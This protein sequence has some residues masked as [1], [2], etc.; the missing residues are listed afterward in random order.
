MDV[1]VAELLARALP[2]SVSTAIEALAP[3][4]KLFGGGLGE[5]L[6]E[7]GL[8]PMYG[9]PTRVR[10][11]Y[12]GLAEDAGEVDWDTVDRD[13]DVAIYEFAPGRTLIRDKRR[14]RAIGFT[15][16]LQKPIEIS[17][18]AGQRFLPLK[19]DAQWYAENFYVA[20]CDACGG[21]RREDLRPVEQLVCDDCGA[22]LPETAFEEYL[23]P[24]AF[25]TDFAPRSDDEDNATPSVRRTTL[26][27]IKDIA[28][29]DVSGTNAS[30]HAGS[31]AA[32]LRLNAGPVGDAGLAL[33]YSVLH[34]DQKG[35]KVP[36]RRAAFVAVSNQFISPEVHA[37]A[38]NRWSVPSGIRD[39]RTGVRLASRKTTDALYI[40]LRQEPPGLALGRMGRKPW[41][42]STR[43]AAVSAT[44]LII[45]RAALELDVAPEEFEG[46]EPRLRRGLPVLQLADYLVN[47]AGFC[48]RLAEPESDGQPMIMRLIRSMVADST[49]RLTG[50]FFQGEHPARCSQACYLCMQRYGNRSYH[51]L[52][53]W[54][55]GIG[56]L[57]ALVDPRYR[58]GLDGNWSAF[59]DIQDWQV[60]ARTAAT[61]IARLRPGQMEVVRAGKM[62]LPAVV[63][64][65]TYGTERYIL[66]HPF[67]DLS[68]AHSGAN[69]AAD[70]AADLGP[71]LTFFVDTFEAVR[72]PIRALD[73]ARDRP[74]N[75][76]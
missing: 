68:G 57:R 43:A 56:F 30:V 27:E 7:H 25:R 23:V 5:F 64:R 2:D 26:A 13:L 40:A 1:R 58:A 37:E 55:L 44:Q 51:G 71:G 41:Q 35:Q 66:V 19:P 61:D 12:L 76:P 74:S 4:G 52:L 16:P 63:W 53:D 29:H 9:M 49:D 17:G 54:R 14:H 22:T 8:L 59:A 39:D 70:A 11:L 75:C 21:P 32:V 20:V 18:S 38:P 69:A 33:G 34:V 46:L 62:A 50:R 72:R 73:A 15:A 10:D 6:A 28:M 24:A 65:R 36:G 48:R 45:Q 47:G 3:A 60:S 67:W 42:T 31:G